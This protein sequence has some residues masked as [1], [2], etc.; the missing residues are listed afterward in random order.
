[1]LVKLSHRVVSFSGECYDF[2]VGIFISLPK[3]VF[4]KCLEIVDVFTCILIILAI[5]DD[6]VVAFLQFLF[7]IHLFECGHLLL[8]QIHEIF[9]VY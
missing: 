5:F 6:K 1:M 4:L 8:V 3:F 7:Q 2:P 9:F